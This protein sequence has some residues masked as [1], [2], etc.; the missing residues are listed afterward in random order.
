MTA[1]RFSDMNVVEFD[2]LFTAALHPEK[3][4]FTRVEICPAD[5]LV[6]KICVD[7]DFDFLTSK[8]QL[9]LVPFIPC[10]INFFEW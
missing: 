8:D 6:P 7:A 2:A 3:L 10:E 9:H 1:G 5:C 4:S